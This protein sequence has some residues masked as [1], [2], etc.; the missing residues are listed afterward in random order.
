MIQGVTPVYKIE[1]GRH[2]G[3]P[4]TRRPSL[5]GNTLG[6]MSHTILRGLDTVHD[7]TERGQME[8]LPL[9]FPWDSTLS[10]LSLADFNL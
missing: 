2:L 5:G 10:H 7:S 3:P 4:R 9:E 8:T 6:I 1:P